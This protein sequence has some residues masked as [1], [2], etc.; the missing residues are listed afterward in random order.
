MGALLF[1][2]VGWAVTFLFYVYARRRLAYWF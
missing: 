1:A 2:V